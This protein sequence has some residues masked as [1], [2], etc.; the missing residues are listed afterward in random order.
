MEAGVLF[1]S[2]FADVP[3]Y[4]PTLGENMYLSYTGGLVFLMA[5]YGLRL[6]IGLAIFGVS[7]G[8]EMGMGGTLFAGGFDLYT[9]SKDDRTSDVS[10]GASAAIMGLIMDVSSEAALRL[11]KNLRLFTKLGVMAAPLSVP[12]QQG[13][14]DYWY[15]SSTG[16]WYYTWDTGYY[17]GTE[18]IP[19][20]PITDPREK[21]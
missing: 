13:W 3:F 2:P 15:D 9:G 5:K 6:D 1:L 14:K 19:P 4:E 18:W 12:E 16:N 21:G 10:W 17:N 8:L 11:G 7:L 20:N